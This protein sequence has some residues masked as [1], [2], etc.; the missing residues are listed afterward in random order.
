MA[1]WLC[2]LTPFLVVWGG[3]PNQTVGPAILTREEFV[4]PFA[5]VGMKCMSCEATRFDM[6]KT[7]KKLAQPPLAWCGIFEKTS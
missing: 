4:A 2:T 3:N 7:Y 6:T 1:S 5:D